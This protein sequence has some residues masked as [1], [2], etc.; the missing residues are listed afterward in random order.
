MSFSVEIPPR[1][2]LDASDEATVV[3]RL[4][5]A[6]VPSSW[7]CRKSESAMAQSTIV[8]IGEAHGLMVGMPSR[9]DPRPSLRVE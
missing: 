1:P 4:L 2:S 5:N 9:E 8:G 6:T 3:G 7:R